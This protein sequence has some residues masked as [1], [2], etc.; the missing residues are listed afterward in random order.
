MHKLLL[1]T[2]NKTGLKYLCY[3]QKIDHDSYPGSGVAWKAHLNEHGYDFSTILLFETSDYDEFKRIAIQKSLEFNVV[4]SDEWANLKLEEGDGGDTISRKR[5]ITD[6]VVDRYLS[7]ESNIPDGW[8]YGRSKCVFNDPMKQREFSK[9]AD[10]SERGK[11][12]KHAWDTGKMDHRD[13][14][15]CGVRGDLNPAKKLE[16]RKKI[17]DSM[18]LRSEELSIRIKKHKPWEKSSR[19]HGKSKISET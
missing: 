16:N 9:R 12:I 7:V 13:N 2:H 14:S 6:G 18:K 1:K 4:E 17:S 5:W 15:K 11:S 8:R 3:T 19:G 10:T